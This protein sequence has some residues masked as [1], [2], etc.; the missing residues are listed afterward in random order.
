MLSGCSTPINV[1]H[2]NIQ[3]AYRINTTNALST[4]TPS[5]A[6]RIVLR[7]QGLLDRFETEPTVV[8]AELHNSLEPVGD[9]DRLFALA[10][11]SMLHAR[12]TKDRAYFLAS[13]VYAW[14]LLFPG[15]GLEIQILPSDPRLR[16]S[17]DIYNQAVAQGLAADDDAEENEVR[18]Q[19]GNYKLPFGTL[20]LSLD[21]SGMVWGGYPLDQFI[22]TNALEIDGLRNR[23]LNS[24]IGVPLAASLAKKQVSENKVA[25]SDRLGPFIKVPVTA[26]LRF[27]NA[28]TNLHN[29]NIQGEIEVYA[30]DQTSTVMIDGQKQFL[31]SDSTAALAY[32]LNDSPIY[33]LELTAFLRG[34]IFTSGLIPKNRVKDGIFFMRPYRP[35]KIPLVLVHGTASSPARWSELANELNGDPKIREH[36]QIWLFVYDSGNYIGYSAGR[37]R[38][39][40]ENTVHE[41]DPE[42]KDSALQQ[43][44]VIG[45]SQG[46]LLTKLTAIDSGTRFWEQISSKPFEQIKVDAETRELLQESM[47]FTPLPF[48]KRVIFIATPHNGAMLAGYQVVTGL[49]SRVLSFPMT[50]LTK[51]TQLATVT[52]DEKLTAFLRRPPTSIDNMNPHSPA[53][54]TLASIPVSSGIHAHSI[55]AVDGYG[56]IEEGDDGVVAYK[57]AHIDEAVSE[58]VVHWGHSCQGQPEVIEEVRRI[59]FEHLKTSE[60]TLP[61]YQETADLPNSFP[62]G[63]RENEK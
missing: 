41:L 37:L 43:M 22:S 15:N 62:G 61:V 49:A 36:F 6:S 26:L 40:L 31:E 32:Q 19:A 54:Q 5:D 55:I 23:Y 2:V 12:N 13:A 56:P 38:K 29:G 3:D 45:H 60:P 24:G 1:K 9:E 63:T 11:L 51:A 21:E 18:L 46:G 34:G 48:V 59:L 33:S 25:G 57:S 7:R 17:Y 8:L 58:L 53:V 27:E 42:G 35:G 30:A 50:I 28:R 47:F 52:G 39:A 44:V 14:S 10:E 4:N 20:Q 16:L